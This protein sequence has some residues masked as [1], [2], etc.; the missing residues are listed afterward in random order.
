MTKLNDGRRVVVSTFAMTGQEDLVSA[1]TVKRFTRSTRARTTRKC[2]RPTLLA[3]IK[4]TRPSYLVIK[5]PGVIFLL[6]NN[7]CEFSSFVT[8]L[9]MHTL[10]LIFVPK[11]FESFTNLEYLDL[12]RNMLQKLPDPIL[13]MKS[14]RFLMLEDNQLTSIAGIQQL[15]NLAYLDLRYNCIQNDPDVEIYQ[16]NKLTVLKITFNPFTKK[17]TTISANNKLLHIF[18][19]RQGLER[20]VELE[21]LKLMPLPIAEVIVDNYRSSEYVY[22]SI[23]IEVDFAS[24]DE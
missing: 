16:C 8:R 21:I 19:N 15:T 17:H 9:E 1:L 13:R 11:I 6:R 10:K 4:S 7:F 5:D 20:V 3:M 23:P 12:S 14:L 22:D 24:D 2:S 18:L